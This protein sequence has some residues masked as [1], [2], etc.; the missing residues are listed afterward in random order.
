M[1]MAGARLV[2][3]IDI[4][5]TNV[6]LA[7][8]DLVNFREISVRKT[9]NYSISAEPYPHH[10]V[11]RLWDFIVRNLAELNRE[12][13]IDAISVTTHGATVA[14]LREDGTLALPILDYEHDGPASVRAEYEEVRPSFEETGT[15]PL[16]VGQNLGAQ[17]FWQQSTFPDAF[18]TVSAILTYPQYWSFR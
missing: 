8:V 17:L 4:S 18:R 13:G 3:V 2:G 6:K 15:P 9:S 14:L 7:L 1:T 10:D 12:Y 16:P 11:D 5:K